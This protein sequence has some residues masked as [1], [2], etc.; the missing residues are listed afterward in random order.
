MF[1]CWAVWSDAIR[2]RVNK[3]FYPFTGPWR[4]IVN[5]L[6]ASYIIEHCSTKKREKWHA[7]DL[8]PYPAELL[9]L[10]PLNGADN[11]YSQINKKILDNPYIQAGIKGFTPPTPFWVP[12]NFLFANTGLEFHRPTL[13]KLNKDLFLCHWDLDTDLPKH[14]DDNEAIPSPGFYTGPPPSTPTYTPDIPPANVL[15]QHIIASQDRLFFFSH[16]IGSGDVHEWRLIHVAF[17][18]T[19]SLYLSCLVDE[20]YLVDFLSSPSI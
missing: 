7:S 4:S 17:E 3:L 19:M 13:A 11:Q 1:A 15:A 20:H 16:A 6:G 2:G 5:L 8:S 18:A 12:S 10:H 14:Q 9:P